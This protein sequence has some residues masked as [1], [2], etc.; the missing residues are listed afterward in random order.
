M[1]LRNICIEIA[2]RVVLMLF[3]IQFLRAVHQGSGTLLRRPAATFRKLL[4]HR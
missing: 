2:W 1:Q 3:V 4:G